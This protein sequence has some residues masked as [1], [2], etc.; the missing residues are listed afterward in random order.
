LHVTTCHGYFKR[1]LL[2]RIFPCWGKKIIAVSEQV[3]AHLL[4]DFKVEAEMVRVIHNGIDLEKFQITNSTSKS[5]A[6]QRLGFDDSPVVG[7]IA[8]LSDVKGHAYLIR[9]FPDILRGYPQ[10]KLLIV[11][12]GKMQSELLRLVKGL[13]IEN[14]VF[15]MPE[16]C[17]TMDMLAAMD[18]FVMPSLKEG[19]GLALMEAMAAALPVIGSDIGGIKSLIK[20]GTTGILVK[21]TDTKGLTA[22]ILELLEDKDKAASLGKNA[23]E[24]IR[25]SF[26]QEL[27]VQ[28]TEALYLECLENQG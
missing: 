15:F 27:M 26:S 7:V 4:D 23:R 2:R 24:F 25:S 12:R 19:L 14:S 11:G 1:R 9:G 8:R 20:H 21:P 18:I 10:A 16:V 5:E 22:S 17:D 6:K 13:G 3:K 28:Q